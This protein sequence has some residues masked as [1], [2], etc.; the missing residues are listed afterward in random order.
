MGHLSFLR[1]AGLPWPEPSPRLRLACS[2]HSARRLGSRA[3]PDRGWALSRLWS[4]LYGAKYF[5]DCAGLEVAKAPARHA[6]GVPPVTAHLRCDGAV[7]RC[8]AVPYGTLIP[9][10]GAK[11]QRSL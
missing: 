5:N 4:S 10:I 7:G 6:K 8:A 1:D 3:A 11:P 9:R 2:C